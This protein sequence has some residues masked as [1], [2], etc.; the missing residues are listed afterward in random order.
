MPCHA[1]QGYQ[2][3]D[4]RGGIS[5]SQ[6]YAPIEA[7]TQTSIEQTQLSYTAVF[8]ITTA[9]GWLLLELLRR[10]WTDLARNIKELEATRG[11]LVQ[12]E[13][14]ASLGRMVAGF[15]HEINTPVG[16]AVGAVSHNEEALTRI[17]KLLGQEE[18]SEEVLREE[19][20]GLRQSG[21]LALTN[22][23]R[24]A[25][26]V[27]SFKRTSIDQ[28]SEQIRSFEMKELISDVLFS[29]HGNLKK[30]PIEVRVQCP[31][32]LQLNG[33][34]GLIQQLLTNLVMNSVQ[35]AFDNGQRAGTIDI[36]AALQGNDV[37]LE[38]SDDGKGMDAGHLSRIFEPFYTTRRGE[39]GSGLGLY[40]CYNIINT[41]LSG[42][43]QCHS[44][45]DAGCRFDI[46]FPARLEKK[47][48]EGFY[49][50]GAQRQ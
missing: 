9:L 46:H 50:A 23:R 34:P 26:L 42:T 38:F 19:L 10:R 24:A 2:I 17:D 20:A 30:L 39:G 36:R 12:S 37:H 43:I 33:M 31:E 6:R 5:V 14:M 41:Q 27:Q 16:V 49:E 44:L 32:S 47:S 22:L 35:H 25:N 28:T 15:A 21:A 8:G 48:E 4:V 45:P 3:G 13:K 1:R 11:E 18:V 40:I 29:L 7:A